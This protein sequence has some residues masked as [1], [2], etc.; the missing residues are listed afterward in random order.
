MQSSESRDRH[1]EVG[2]KAHTSFRWFK[3]SS[4]CLLGLAAWQLMPVKGPKRTIGGTGG[5]LE[6]CLLCPAIRL[7]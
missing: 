5:R 6:P 4:P 2:P 3:D 7:K 1:A